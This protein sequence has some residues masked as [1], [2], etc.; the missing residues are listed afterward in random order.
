MLS[1][2]NGQRE[3]VSGVSLDEEMTNL[4]TY[5][6]GYQASARMMTTIDTVLNTLINNTG[7]GLVTIARI[8][9]LMTT[10][11]VLANIN[12]AQNQL[13][14]TQEELSSGKRI[15]Q[16]SDDP[17]GASEAVSLNDTLSQ[18]GD[19]SDQITDGTAWAQASDTALQSIQNEVQRVRELV[20]EAANGTNSQS[21]LSS[22]NSEI[23]Q[24][25]ASIKQDANA[26]Y[27]GQYIFSGTATGTAPYTTSSDAYQ[28]NTG[29][30]N[31]TIGP[32]TTL[33]VNADVSS[34]LGSG[35]SAGDGKL[36]NVLANI[37][38]DLTS[39]NTD[40]AG[41]HRPVGT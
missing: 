27:N 20:V 30:V 4:I 25:T 17:Y 32:A 7:A 21:N 1:A 11:E 35:Q 36:L 15:N 38:S 23:T 10:Q 8:T 18:L 22:I 26:Q 9:N 14:T 24:L 33:Q 5:Q 41:L 3:S 13:D 16:P 12:A 6:Q 19:Y 29:A 39:G 31:R 34:V 37:S 40:G 2:I 28:G